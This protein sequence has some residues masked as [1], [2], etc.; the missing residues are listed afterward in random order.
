[1]KLIILCFCLYFVLILAQN[2][3]NITNCSVVIRD[4]ITDKERDELLG[5]HNNYRNSI[6]AG[7]T[8]PQPKASDMKVMIWDS[9]LEEKAQKW[10]NF[11]ASK[12]SMF[13]SGGGGE[14]IFEGASY[15]FN[16]ITVS[17]AVILWFNENKSFKYG[18]QTNVF[19]NVGHYTQVVWNTSN[20]LGCGSTIY[21]M[22]LRYIK[23]VVVCNYSPSGNSVSRLNRPY[24][25]GEPCSACGGQCN[26]NY[27][28]LC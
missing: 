2:A 27:T 24:T 22:G 20:K 23:R 4:Y 10:A 11:L 9:A 18:N 17:Y 15:D 7:Q 14:N 1:M 12:C 21:K 25:Q 13:H 19:S 5:M 8:P 16:K 26:K 3:S 28:A 6:A